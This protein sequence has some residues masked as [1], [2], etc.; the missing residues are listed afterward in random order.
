MFILTKNALKQSDTGISM[1]TL[2]RVGRWNDVFF[3]SVPPSGREPRESV[4]KGKAIKNKWTRKVVGWILYVLYS[5][6]FLIIKL[7]GFL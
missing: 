2:T 5:N 6:L 1:Q 3:V 4:C 7:I